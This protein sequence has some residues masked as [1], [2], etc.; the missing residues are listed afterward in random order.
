MASLNSEWSNQC[1][2]ISE[3]PFLVCVLNAS[4]FCGMKN[5]KVSVRRLRVTLIVTH[6]HHLPFLSL[7]Y[8]VCI[9]YNYQHVMCNVCNGISV[10]QKV[11]NKWFTLSLL[12]P[13]LQG[14]CSRY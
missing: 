12:Q 4:T 13:T 7:S 14:R 2:N 10:S 6:S 9:E 5:V 1:L 8:F 3:T 11:P